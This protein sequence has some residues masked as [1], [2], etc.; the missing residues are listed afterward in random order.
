MWDNV[1]LLSRNANYT[2]D[3]IVLFADTTSTM[4]TWMGGRRYPC[5]F[6][7]SHLDIFLAF[8][9]TVF[10]F[11]D[12]P[13]RFFSVMTTTGI[14][15]TVPWGFFLGSVSETAYPLVF[16]PKWK[17]RPPHWSQNIQISCLKKFLKIFKSTQSYSFKLT[18]LFGIRTINSSL[19][20]RQM[21]KRISGSF[22]L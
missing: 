10:F 4:Y 19:R 22:G 6:F 5:I 1:R 9:I 21:V 13:Q 15:L 2:E 12:S 3:N 20:A 11:Y 7:N 17:R 16:H 8:V 18:I 14:F